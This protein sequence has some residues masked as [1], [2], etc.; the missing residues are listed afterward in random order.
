MKKTL[1]L[2]VM[3]LLAGVATGYS[4]GQLSFSD[5]GSFEIQ[6]YGVQAQAA[7]PV[8]YGGFTV[9]EVMGDSSNPNNSD[10]KSVV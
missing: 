9:N 10:R 7:T 5:A 6:V 2:T 4:Q 1:T 3:T 8:T